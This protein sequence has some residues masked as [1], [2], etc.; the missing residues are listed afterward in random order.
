VRACC[1]PCGTSDEAKQD[2]RG[3]VDHDMILT[4]LPIVAVSMAHL[5]A[6]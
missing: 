4:W 1:D 3:V 2:L 5:T 6:A